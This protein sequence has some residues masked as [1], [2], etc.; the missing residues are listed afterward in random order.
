LVTVV[1]VEA[2][3]PMVA[4]AQTDLVVQGAVLETWQLILG[5]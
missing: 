5:Q 1:T 3:T 4:M 2:E